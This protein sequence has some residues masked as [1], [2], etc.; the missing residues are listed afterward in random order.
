MK[1]SIPLHLRP[2]TAQQHYNAYSPIDHAVWRYVMR[3]NHHFLEDIAHDAFTSGLKSS[4]ISIDSIPRVSEMNDH[5][6]KI[7]WGA[8]IVDGLIP[9]TAF[10][11]FQAHGILQ[12]QRIYARRPISNTHPLLTFSMKPRGMRRFYLMKHTQSL[13]N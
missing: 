13:L 4:G 2:F 11:D 12:L 7:G 6:D 8:V 10:F 9:G 5:L 3:Q 1:K